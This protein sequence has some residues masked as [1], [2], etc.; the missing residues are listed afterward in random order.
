MARGKVRGTRLKVFSGKEASLNRVILGILLSKRLLTKYD[1]FLEVRKTKGFRHRDSK[2]IYRRVDAL[3]R[4]TWIR[5]EGKRPGKVQGE[6]AQYAITLKG[7]AALK[8][9]EVNIEEFLEKASEEQLVKFV[10]LFQ[11]QERQV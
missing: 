1:V 5:Q 4:E 11:K 8:L 6:S 3:Y 10:G 7:K 9:D 2:T